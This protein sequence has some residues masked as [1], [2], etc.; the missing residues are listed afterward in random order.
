MG[1]DLEGL[2]RDLLSQL[3]VLSQRPSLI[4]TWRVGTGRSRDS[5]PDSVDQSRGKA[6]TPMTPS[7]PLSLSL[8]GK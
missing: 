1:K 5:L 7:Q 3:P 6:S 8:V 4:V 2:P